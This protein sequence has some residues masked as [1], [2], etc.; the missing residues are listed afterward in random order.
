[1]LSGYVYNWRPV[2]QK[3]TRIPLYLTVEQNA[4]YP[5]AIDELTIEKD[6]SRGAKLRQSKCF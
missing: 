1:M 2:S 6:L 3:A 4:A 5:K